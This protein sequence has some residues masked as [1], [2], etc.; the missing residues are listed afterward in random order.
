MIWYLWTNTETVLDACAR[1]D[2]FYM[3]TPGGLLVFNNNS[4]VK[5]YT[6][7]DGLMSA[8][9]LSVD[10]NN[11]VWVLTSRGLQY[12]TGSGFSTVELIAFN[13]PQEVLEGKR[14]RSFGNFMFILGKSRIISYRI[15]DSTEIPFPVS[16]SKPLFLDIY[17]DTLLV[18]DTSG[19]YKVKYD[20]F[21]LNLWD[22][23][24]VGRPV[25]SAVKHITYGW[26]M[27][28]DTGIVDTLGNI[29]WLGGKTIRFLALRGDTIWAA[30]MSSVY[31]ILPPFTSPTKV[32]DG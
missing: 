21:N 19:F 25:F 20:D 16:F 17:T 18:G 12:L 14:I 13:D 31:K 32:M 8:E 23:V 26:I 6:T 1:N 22:T 3:A 9:V 29:L 28:T 4:I 10:C 11:G 5:K 30:T 2:T 7:L 27:G 15:S 24:F